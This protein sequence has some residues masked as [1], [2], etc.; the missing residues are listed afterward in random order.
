MSD[1]GGGGEYRRVQAEIEPQRVY[2]ESRA[3]TRMW[4]VVALL[5]GLMAMWASTW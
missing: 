2:P 3:G 4:G 5:A 1:V